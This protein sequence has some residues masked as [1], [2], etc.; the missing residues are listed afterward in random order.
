MQNLNT[1]LRIA[2]YPPPGRQHFGGRIGFSDRQVEP[3]RTEPSRI[4]SLHVCTVKKVTSKAN[5]KDM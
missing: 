5:E 4:S 2:R 3:K 1:G